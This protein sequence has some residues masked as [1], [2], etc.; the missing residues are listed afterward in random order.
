LTAA[1]ADVMESI[2]TIRL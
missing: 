1:A 2:E